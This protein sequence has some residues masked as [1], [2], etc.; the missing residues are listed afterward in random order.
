MNIHIQNI[1]AVQDP[2]IDSLSMPSSTGQDCSRGEASKSIENEIL[3]YSDSSKSH[4]ETFRIFSQSDHEDDEQPPLKKPNTNNSGFQQVKTTI[5]S[6]SANK[7]KETIQAKQSSAP[8]VTI[9]P[10]LSIAGT[11]LPR[12]IDADLASEGMKDDFRST[13]INLNRLLCFRIDLT[14]EF[15]SSW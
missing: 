12:E 1:I 3:A 5:N 13:K 4:N 14:N 15:F 11:D 9:T 7:F 2:S 10:P 6:T 8:V